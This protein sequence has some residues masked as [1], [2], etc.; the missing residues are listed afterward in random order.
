MDRLSYI[1]N[2]VEKRIKELDEKSKVIKKV[3]HR[4]VFIVYKEITKIEKWY[5]SKRNFLNYGKKMK[6]TKWKGRNKK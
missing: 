4:D 1:F 2:S 6:S 5:Y 3:A